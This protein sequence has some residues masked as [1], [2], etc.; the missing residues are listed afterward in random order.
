MAVAERLAASGSL[1]SPA[2]LPH[3]RTHARAGSLVA[4]VIAEHRW[5]NHSLLLIRLNE[6]QQRIVWQRLRSA[7]RVRLSDRV[8][9]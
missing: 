8:G 6:R 7:G 5:T 2:R 3:M 4:D 9:R 1:L